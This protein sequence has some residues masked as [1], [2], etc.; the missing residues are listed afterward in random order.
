MGHYPFA[1]FLSPKN[2]KFNVQTIA[3]VYC[4]PFLMAAI[5]NKDLS[6]PNHCKKL[7]TIFC[8]ESSRESD[9]SREHVNESTSINVSLFTQLQ[10]SSLNQTFE[11]QM[12]EHHSNEKAT[13]EKDSSVTTD[14]LIGQNA[15][16]SSDGLMREQ[17]S[18]FNITNEQ[19]QLFSQIF[20]P[21]SPISQWISVA[22]AVFEIKSNTL[23]IIPPLYPTSTSKRQ[24][25][26]SPRKE[27]KKL[28]QE[29]EELNLC[30]R[31]S[32]ARPQSPN[33][34]TLPWHSGVENWT[35]KN[36][37]NVCTKC[38]NFILYNFIYHL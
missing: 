22:K 17:M 9:K 7:A 36:G 18:N 27:N 16:C 14:S 15:Q 29:S 1:I 31:T 6:P 10:Q 4:D 12:V 33:E 21:G 11:K 23:K 5:S 30:I 19:I 20:H 13:C 34:Q 28:E 35:E 32:S 3:E 8:K 2:E 24:R 26:V 37:N 25:V 38:L